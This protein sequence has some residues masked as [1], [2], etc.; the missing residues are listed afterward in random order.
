MIRF[1]RDIVA[2]FLLGMVVFYWVFVAYE[3]LTVY[4][5]AQTCDKTGT[6]ELNGIEYICFMPH[7]D[8]VGEDSNGSQRH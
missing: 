2:Q 5:I 1:L 4:E 6:V 8:A 3:Y 7:P